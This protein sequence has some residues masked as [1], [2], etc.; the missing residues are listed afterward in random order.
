ML[1]DRQPE[2]N[3][4]LGER[5]AGSHS[6][7][8]DNT[9]NPEFTLQTPEWD[10]KI[11]SLSQASQS[12]FY[13]FESRND[14]HASAAY[15]K[16]ADH[17]NRE[18]YLNSYGGLSQFGMRGSSVLIDAVPALL[19][20]F[21]PAAPG[22]AGVAWGTKVVQLVQSTFAK[23]FLTGATISG[24]AEIGR[25]ELSVEERGAMDLIL[26]TS[27]G[28]IAHGAFSKST[29]LAQV[30]AGNRLINNATKIIRE[31]G[32]VSETDALLNTFKSQWAKE[33]NGIDEWTE[34]LQFNLASM[35]A[36][37]ESD[38]MVNLGNDLFFKRTLMGTET[39]VLENSKELIESRLLAASDREIRP[40]LMK[41]GKEAPKTKWYSL[42]SHLNPKL[43][44]D[45]TDI[46]GEMQMSKLTSENPTRADILDVGA[47]RLREVFGY[48]KK[49]AED[50]AEELLSSAERM[51]YNSHGI[52]AESG[53]KSFAKGPNDTAPKIPQTN[54]YMPAQVSRHKFNETVQKYGEQEV[55]KL[56]AKSIKQAIKKRG[57]TYSKGTTNAV[58]KALYKK[59]VGQHEAPMLTKMDADGFRNMVLDNLSLKETAKLDMDTVDFLAGTF[60]SSKASMKEGSK[61]E[62]TRGFFDY[63]T[64]HTTATGD[65]LSW[66]D[67]LETNFDGAWN[68]YAR[69]QAGFNTLEK[70]GLS[71][72]KLRDAKRTQIND[73]LIA[74]KIDPEK[75]K[76]ELARYDEI[77][78]D[79]EGRPLMDDP[80]SSL[81]QGIRI[82]NNVGIARLLGNSG[83]SMAAEANNMVWTVGMKHMFN[84]V[85]VMK[86]MMK[87]FRTGKLEDGVIQ[88]IYDVF[89]MMGEL[90]RGVGHT[91]FDPDYD[92]LATGNKK[93]DW[94]EEKSNIFKEITLL[95]GGIKPLTAL[96]EGVTT[97][98][99]LNNVRKAAILSSKGKKIPKNLESQL[100][101]MGL[102]GDIRQAIFN[103]ITKHSSIV[104]SKGWGDEISKLN[105]DKWDQDTLHKLIMGTRT[106]TH[107]IVQKSSLGDKVGA[108][109]GGK[110]LENTPLG[111]LSFALKN[112]VITSW[113]KQLQRGV[114]KRKDLHHMGMLSSQMAV[115]SLAAMAQIY[116][117]YPTDAKKRAEL[118]TPEHIAAITFARSTPAAFLPQIYDTGADVVQAVTGKDVH[119]FQDSRSSGLANSIT[120]SIP[121]IDTLSAIG[122]IPYAV[123]GLLGDDSV[124]SSKMKKG[125]SALPG[126]NILGID[127][128]FRSLVE[129]QKKNNKGFKRRN[130]LFS[131]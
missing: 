30:E 45:I 8:L 60:K 86:Q 36:K 40:L 94:M 26:A 64:R 55:R 10:T 99:I 115:V 98:G 9:A 108:T 48:T 58:A 124:T 75:I 18:K 129:D 114:A 21:S 83:F 103:N 4:Y 100:T 88:E 29:D 22:V 90:T 43:K 121:A 5:G 105:T 101:D 47:F 84:N 107:T 112:Y 70:L 73:E 50:L 119:L 2:M 42:P 68:P 66:M 41:M 38:S 82:T 111:K 32:S 17:D 37:S 65:E 127:A 95:A 46:M 61:H 104:K 31:G 20:S 89:G 118:I 117:R 78:R 39:D 33:G 71:T 74:K 80:F 130:R 85:G 72:K 92:V 12:Y 63:A 7:G 51:S 53:S 44:R 19:A 69:T 3:L 15:E 62:Q 79:L 81:N 16:A 131:D 126:Q 34:S 128:L 125:L 102:S 93:A 106:L 91:R 27:I 54:D 28:G 52:L 1:G 25:M 56:L 57:G 97:T 116:L 23:R 59:M 87:M 11:G 122:S 77:M 35:T 76:S 14:E 96:F 13:G 109:A 110:L 49:E 113:G 24:L 123:R 6:I 120:G 67:L